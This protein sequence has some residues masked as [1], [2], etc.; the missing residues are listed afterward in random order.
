[1]V[2]VISYSCCL[3]LTPS[4]V[5]YVEHQ[6]NKDHKLLSQMDFDENQ[7]LNVRIVSTLSISSFSATQ[8]RKRFSFICHLVQMLF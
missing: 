5:I 3:L 1:M 7:Q 4:F 6:P 8:V 2:R